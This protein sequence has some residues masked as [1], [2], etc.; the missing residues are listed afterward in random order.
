MACINPDG[1]LTRT[2][3]KVMEALKTPSTEVE[4]A[5]KVGFPVYL[6]RSSLRELEEL[7]LINE[8]EGTYQPT[9]SGFMK[10]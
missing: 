9:E 8:T 10:L 4:I 5:E 6:V 3:Q 2:G 1:T 7:G